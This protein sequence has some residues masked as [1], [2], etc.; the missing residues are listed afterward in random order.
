MSDQ[1]C[2]YQV[3]CNGFIRSSA[4]QILEPEISIFSFF[5]HTGSFCIQLKKS[6]L[7]SVK[8]VRFA[9]SRL[10][11]SVNTSIPRQS[12]SPSAPLDHSSLASGTCWVFVNTFP[13]WSSRLLLGDR[14]ELFNH[15]GA[16]KSPSTTATTCLLMFAKGYKSVSVH[17]PFWFRMFLESGITRREPI[18]YSGSLSV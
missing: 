10:S 14:L 3:F 15:R 16:A 9:V 12:H 7:N 6:P 17:H 13:I 18:R 8:C 11:S 2:V 4:N 5:L 1:I